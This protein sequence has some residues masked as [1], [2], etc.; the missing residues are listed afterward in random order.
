MSDL[1]SGDLAELARRRASTP[2]ANEKGALRSIQHAEQ[3]YV[4]P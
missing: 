3:A 2:G 4:I 1:A